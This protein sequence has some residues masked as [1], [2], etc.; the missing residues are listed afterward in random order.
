MVSKQKWRQLVKERMRVVDVRQ[1]QRIEQTL[2]QQ[3]QAYDVFQQARTVGLT[4]SHGVEWDTQ[5]IV[6]MCQQMGKTVCVPRTNSQTKEMTFVA[7]APHTP[8]VKA[9]FGIQ[10]PESGQVVSKT[11]IDLLIVPGVVF[12]PDGYRIGFGG[13][14]YDRYLC[15]FPNRTVALLADFQIVSDFLVESHDIP[16]EK[17]LIASTEN[18]IM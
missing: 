13:G 8:F 1:R 9:A 16:V 11:D 2:Y 18:G 3:L 10:E 4:L 17:L 5:P 7:V 6:A 15:D 14:Y 12:S